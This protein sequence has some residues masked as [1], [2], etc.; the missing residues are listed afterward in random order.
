MLPELV[1]DVGA[2]NKYSLP[3]HLHVSACAVTLAAGG[4]PTM[5]VSQ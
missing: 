2:E 3:R 1:E 5:M 4:M